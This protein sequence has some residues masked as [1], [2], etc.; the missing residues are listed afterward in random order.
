MESFYREAFQ[1]AETEFFD[2]YCDVEASDREN[3]EALLPIYFE[4][5]T[6]ATYFS[7]L[8]SMGEVV[9]NSKLHFAME[10]LILSYRLLCN[11]RQSFDG[12]VPILLHTIPVE[13]MDAVALSMKKNQLLGLHALEENFDLYEEG[14]WCEFQTLS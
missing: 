2:R 7:S 10:E 13:D 12:N 1:I 4:K 3:Y 8:F 11:F 6:A 9:D 14:K 5:Y